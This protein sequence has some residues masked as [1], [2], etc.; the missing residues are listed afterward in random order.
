VNLVP[1]EKP[2]DPY[3]TVCNRV[4]EKVAEDV[5][6]DDPAVC[7]RVHLYVHICVCVCVCIQRVEEV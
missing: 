3:T 4:I 7:I 5:N 2:S 6:S 1:G